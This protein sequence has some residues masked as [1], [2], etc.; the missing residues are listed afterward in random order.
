MKTTRKQ[1]EKYLRESFRAPELDIPPEWVDAHVCVPLR[2][3]MV[4]GLLADFILR[5]QHNEV[6]QDVVFAVL[7]PSSSGKAL[8]TVKSYASKYDPS[9]RWA[10][11]DKYGRGCASFGGGRQKSIEVPSLAEFV[12]GSMGF[13]TMAAGSVSGNLFAPNNQWLFKVMLLSGMDKRYW[14]GPQLGRMF[15]I[16]ELA[17]IA[18]VPQPSVSR[19]VALAEEQGFIVRWHRGLGMQS[20]PRLLDQWTYYLRNSL[21]LSMPVRP[22]YKDHMKL[23]DWV[24]LSGNNIVAGGEPAIR[25]M[26]LSIRNTGRALLYARDPGQALG[27]HDLME[28]SRKES[29]CELRKPKAERS[30]FEGAVSQKGERVADIL[31]LYLDARLSMARGEEQAQHIFENVLAPLFREKKWL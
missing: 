4:R 22:L 2:V 21:D 9:L 13:A 16:S 24:K 17:D 26:G 1:R 31:Q 3:E 7:V 30:I 11:L 18:R 27:E 8:D 23:K 14:G 12:L 10:V 20:I 29:V 6:G 15:G 28:C 5:K 19:F 25:A